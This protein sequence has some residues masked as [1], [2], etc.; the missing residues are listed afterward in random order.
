MN[1]LLQNLKTGSNVI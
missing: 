1:K